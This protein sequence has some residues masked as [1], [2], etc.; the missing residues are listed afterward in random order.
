[1]STINPFGKLKVEH[2]NDSEEEGYQ[3]I[4]KNKVVQN[5]ESKKKKKVRPQ[6][7]EKEN[8]KSEEEEGFE[9]VN[10][11]QKRQHYRE[12]NDEYEKKDHFCFSCDN[13]YST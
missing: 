4:K 5:P 7:Q 11:H 13:T 8:N 6:E 1:M 10:K 3:E 12:R 2:E 9:E